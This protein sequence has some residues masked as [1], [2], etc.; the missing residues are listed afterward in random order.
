MSYMILLVVCLFLLVV[1]AKVMEKKNKTDFIQS[2]KGKWGKCPTR[3]YSLDEFEKITHHFLNKGPDQCMIDD[4]TWNDLDMNHIFM[5]INRAYS[6]VGDS[7][8][9][10][11]LRRPKFDVKVLEEQKRL[12][13]YFRLNETERLRL[14][15]LFGK[16]GRTK[17]VSLS[18]YLKNMKELEL[19]SN[20]KHYLS[21]GLIPVSIVSFVLSPQLGILCVIGMLVYNII[22]YYRMKAKIESYMLSVSYMIRLLTTAKQMIK[23]GD[24]NLSA[25]NQDLKEAVT[26]LKKVEKLA[27]Y[28]TTGKNSANAALE[29]VIF[30]YVRMI[31]H[32][33][34]I[35]FTKIAKEMQANDNAVQKIYELLG[36]IEAM[37][38]IASFQEMLPFYS[39][40]ILTIDDTVSLKLD[41]VYHPMIENPVVNSIQETNNILIT[42]SNAS[43]K[44]TFLKTIAINALLSQT[45]YVATAKEYRAN[46][47]RI[48]SSMALTD[49][50][51]G[52]ESYFMVEIKSLKRILD[53]DKQQIPVLCFIDEVL[54]GTNTIERI[55]ASAQILFSLKQSNVFCFAATHDIELT[56]ILEDYYKNYHFTEEVREE[57]VLF[58]YQLMPGRAES[59]NAIKLLKVIGYD[60]SIIEEA[61]KQAAEFMKSNSW[62]KL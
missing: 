10:D 46:F 21:I 42:G 32:M 59:R 36:F 37:I 28:I 2:E 54:R 4:I 5:L 56:Y 31:T 45:I 38:S 51:Q 27:P 17:D 7:Y 14:Q 11:L 43:G 3:E 20:L 8:L 30:D 15:I 29:E 41:S 33:D 58:S 6:S 47:F 55:A 50:L 24:S 35:F 40:P 26:K 1:Y 44:S 9:Y 34:L 39:T 16:L 23:I 60:Q 53:S 49:N 22:S 13:D 61:E 19:S 57:D 25:Y 48:Y 12:T 18:D 62:R 52:K